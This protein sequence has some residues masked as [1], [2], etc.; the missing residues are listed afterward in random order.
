LAM[1]TPIQSIALAA[2]SGASRTS[3]S[4]GSQISAL[5]VRLR[6]YV[7]TSVHV[8]TEKRPCFGAR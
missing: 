6:T 7:A 3:E 1:V 8:S 4:V 5:S 2:S